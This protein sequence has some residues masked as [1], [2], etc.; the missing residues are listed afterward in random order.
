MLYVSFLATMIVGAPRRKKAPRQA[1]AEQS[2][3][4]PESEDERIQQYIENRDYTGADTFISFLRS[5]LKQS[6]TKERALWHG[7]S[8]FHCGKYL[9]VI[10]VY[11]Q[12]LETEPDETNLHLYIASC[13]F[14]NQDY[15]DARQ[16]A[17]K[18]PNCDLRTRLIFHIAHQLNDEQ[19]LLDAHSRLVGTLE[20]QLSLAAIH[21]L[22]S[23]YQDAIEIYGSLL[24]Q[25]PEFI[26]LSVY[27]A[28]CQFKLERFEQSNELVDLYLG[29]NS[30]SAVALNL[31]SCDYFRLFGQEI[32]E[33][34]LL[35]IKKFSTAAYEFVDNRVVHNLCIFQN[36]V[37]GFRILPKLVH[38]IPE[39]RYNLAVLYLRDN[40]PV[41]ANEILQD[42]QAIELNESILKASILLALGQANSEAPQIE[43]ANSM[44]TEIINLEGVKDTVPGR[45]CHASTKFIV[46][47]YDAALKILQTIESFV[48]E[49]DEYNYDKAMTLASLSKW[50]EA[51]KAFLMVKNPAY[52][53]EI[54]YMRWL[55][56]CYIKNKKPEEA[57]NLYV[58]ATS[59]EDSKTLL[60]VIAADYYNAGMFFYAMKS[61]DVL[62]K[63]EPEPQYRDGLIAAA[64][65][66]FRAILTKQE[67][68]DRLMDL[69][70]ALAS[71][72]SA[73]PVLERIQQYQV[74]SGE[75]DDL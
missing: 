65:G 5:E 52:T 64:V 28:M 16:S 36:G 71:E 4:T 40:N 49:L 67:T 75:Y 46:G 39:A 66:V 70:N 18:G 62:A 53:K 26:A 37:D 27:M 31:K 57:W 60:R 55:A 47:E 44:F 15:E 56:R 19:A 50:Q 21:Y 32:A 2:A 61:Y 7:Y 45:E 69:M 24:V 34:Q 58:D 20:N 22:R 35:Q 42:F 30:D 68:P 13:H 25:H 48:D 74:E 6:H 14:Y 41:E 43:E 33:S 59:T 63:F 23:H 1:R 9:E 10:R 8:L 29:E 54:F 11:E 12:L 51:E 3:S 38:V 73:G 72:P 17:Q